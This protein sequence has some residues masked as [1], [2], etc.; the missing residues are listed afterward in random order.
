MSGQTLI[1]AQELAALTGQSSF[2]QYAAQQVE[3]RNTQEI[4][5]AT[6]SSGSFHMSDQTK[7][8]LIQDAG[9]ALA[10]LVVIFGAHEA[11]LSSTDSQ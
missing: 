8:A 7:N 10:S 3:Q 4:Q 5:T 9:K 1:S 2:N 6:Q 11:S